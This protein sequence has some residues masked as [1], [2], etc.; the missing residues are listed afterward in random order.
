M[1]ELVASSCHGFPCT[2]EGAN[3]FLPVKLLGKIRE[4]E[5][6]PTVTRETRPVVSTRKIE[7]RQVSV[8]SYLIQHR[9]R[10]TF[11]QHTPTIIA[12][13]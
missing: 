4:H 3:D 7:R 10:R 1:I 9:I 12:K 5:P 13:G 8:A 6:W 2:D 11:T